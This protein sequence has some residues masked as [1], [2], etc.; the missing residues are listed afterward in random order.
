[1]RHHY[2][3]D[4][5]TLAFWSLPAPERDARLAQVRRDQPVSWQ[6]P[7]EGMATL[8]GRDD[9]GFW[10]VLRLEDVTTVSRRPELYCSGQGIMIEDLPEEILEAASSFLATDHPRHTSLRRLVSAGFTPRRVALL[11]DKIS[12]MAAELVDELVA[13]G[14]GDFVETLSKRLPAMTFA[15]MMGVPDSDRERICALAN[16]MVSWN[17]AEALDGRDGLTLLM[18]TLVGLYGVA[19]ELAAERRANPAED[20]LGGLV[21]AEVDGQMLT[22]ED[23]A[24]FFVLLAVAANDTTKQ[25]ISYGMQA[26]CDFPEQRKLLDSDLERYLPDAIEEMVRWASPVM[27]FRRTATVDSELAGQQI[28]AG[29]KVVMY[30]VSAN[31]DEDAFSGPYEFDITRP[32]AHV[33]FGGGGPHFCLGA[34]LART[35]LRAAFTQLITKAPDL[36]VSG[37]EYL[38]GNFIQGIT[39]MQ[40]EL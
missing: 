9:P 34:S 3:I 36:Q 15:A 32:P 13:Q 12:S 17:D 37:A 26:L 28:L 35:M 31:R 20:I 21:T 16:D 23:I 6:R 7:A 29:D 40:Y 27:T 14:S 39:T 1:M 38:I 5:S 2:E 8:P 10:A 19:A 33:G 25:T 30:Y 24:A 4:V 11:E 18:E 22:D